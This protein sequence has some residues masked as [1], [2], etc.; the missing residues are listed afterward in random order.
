MKKTCIIGT[1]R[2]GQALEYLLKASDFNPNMWDANP[3]MPRNVDDLKEAV[4][5]VDVIFIG[6]PSWAVRVVITEVQEHAKS[7]VVFVIL[8]KGIEEKTLKTMDLLLAEVITDAQSYALLSGPTMA[9]EILNGTRAAAMVASPNPDVFETLQELFVNSRLVLEYSEEVHS[10]A[11]TAV[12]KNIYAMSLGMA[13]ALE[14]SGNAN[15]TLIVHIIREMRVIVERLGGNSDMVLSLAGLGDMVLTGFSKHSHNRASGKDLL[16]KG[17][18]S[19]KS[20]GFT[21]L[22]PLIDLLE[23]DLEDLPLLQAL[24][25]I[26]IEGVSAQEVMESYLDSK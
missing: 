6:V 2:I 19:R 18:L 12:L 13:S 10:V 16:E 14:V 5:D 17:E 24:Q 22:P 4:T 8:S 20:E 1:G 7:D 11:L 23:N 9:E 26:V 3:E 15:G 25:S 21:A